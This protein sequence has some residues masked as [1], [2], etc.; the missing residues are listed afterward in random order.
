MALAFSEGSEFGGSRTT[1]RV[2]S[3]G[4]SGQVMEDMA[5]ERLHVCWMKNSEVKSS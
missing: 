4:F 2:C 5:A 3:F 1:G